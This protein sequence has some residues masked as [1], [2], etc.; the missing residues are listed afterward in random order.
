MSMSPTEQLSLLKDYVLP[1]IHAANLTAQILVYDHNWD[2][3]A[4]PTSVLSDTAVTAS[5]NVAGIAWHWYGGVPGAMTTLH[6]LYPRLNNY[7]TE[8]SGGTW[9]T[10]EVKQD[11]EMIVH[12]MRNWASAYVKW[13]LAL[14]QNHGPHSGGCATCT[15]LVTID[16]S[17]GVVSYPIDYYTLGHFSKFVLPG[18]V[19]LWSSNA[20]GLISA[21][22]ATPD[23][24][25][26]L[27]AYND[28]SADKSFEVSWRGRSLVYS[29]PA[30]AGATFTWIANE[31]ARGGGLSTADILRQP[32]RR[33]RYAIA[34]TGQIQAS[35]YTQIANLQSEACNDAEGGFDI[36]YSADGGWLE[37]DN[38]D[39]G[40]GLTT[41]DM[42]W[43]SA[44]SGGALE[45]HLDSA[46][47][48]TIAQG[49]LPV[50]GGWQIWRT[51]SMP[52]SGAQGLHKVFVVF[53]GSGTN[54]S[55]N[56]NWFRFQ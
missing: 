56:L 13:G 32:V 20:P 5:P 3:P 10:D 30:L 21:A 40:T 52:V 6:N 36:G 43:A 31:G 35:S 8:A 47:G 2:Q 15:P 45:F 28:S 17:T 38:I 4:Y 24:K 23:G 55:G 44:G 26:V 49:S 37:F 34:A 41:V 25:V 9:I 16:S 14:D 19:A 48:P 12:S 50:T 53:R 22:F 42:R 18:S 54:G 11:F 29:L 46:S 33:P 1:A 39:F 7:V 51:F 27:V